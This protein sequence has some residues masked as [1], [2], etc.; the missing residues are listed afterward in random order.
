MSCILQHYIESSFIESYWKLY[1]KCIE[2]NFK[3]KRLTKIQM[4]INL[5]LNLNAKIWVQT[6]QYYLEK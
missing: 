4:T 1:W 6:I 5:L 3:R 2:I